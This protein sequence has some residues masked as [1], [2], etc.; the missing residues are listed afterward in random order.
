MCVC[1]FCRGLCVHDQEVVEL[2][3]CV[4]G[5]EPEPAEFVCVHSL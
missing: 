1:T 4:L 5:H 2:C 3:V